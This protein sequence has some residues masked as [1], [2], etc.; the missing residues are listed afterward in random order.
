MTSPGR[1]KKQ[2]VTGFI[3]IKFFARLSIFLWGV[4]GSCLLGIHTSEISN[5]HTIK[6][7]WQRVDIGGSQT[8][9][10][11]GQ[12]LELDKSHEVDEETAC[13]EDS[14]LKNYKKKK[15]SRWVVAID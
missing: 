12:V 10:L 13:K 9:E 5:C 1:K 3:S 15:K 4:A 14:S 7:A 2:Q 8:V 11:V 6:L